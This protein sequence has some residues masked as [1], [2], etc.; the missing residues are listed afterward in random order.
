M[1]KTLLKDIADRMEEREVILTLLLTGIFLLIC[2]VAGTRLA[3]ID[4]T[5][6]G[7]GEVLET[8]TVHIS[9]YG[10]PFEML[11]IFQP[12]GGGE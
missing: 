10:L 7:Y 5:Y 6:P 11:G 12:I 8:H 9:Y 1:I 2:F 4:I 3:S